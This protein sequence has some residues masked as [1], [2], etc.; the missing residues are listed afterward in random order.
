MSTAQHNIH[1]IG[2]R[3]SS[4]CRV[5]LTKGTGKIFVNRKPMESYFDTVNQ[6]HAVVEALK[7]L[8]VEK[9]FDILC[10]PKGGGKC[11][12]AGAVRLAIARALKNYE[13]RITGGNVDESEGAKALLPWHRALRDNELLTCDSRQVERKKF[14]LLGA[15]KRVQY[16]KR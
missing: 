6:R 15:R 14:G 8:E 10:F 4:T 3:K 11:G 16:S 7:A 12:Q 2:R 5:Y 1:T 9:D 13:A